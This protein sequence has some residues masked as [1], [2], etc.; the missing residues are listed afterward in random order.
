[1]KKILLISLLIGCTL[2]LKAIKHIRWGTTVDP[3]NGLT[4]TWS[5]TGAADSIQWGYTTSFEKGSSLGVKRAGY[6]GSFFNYVFP[7]LNPNSTI[8]YKLYDSSTKSWGTQM[9]YKTAPPID[10]KNFSFLGLGDSRSGVSTWNKISLLADAKDVALTVFNGDIVNSGSSA[11]DW[12]GWFDNGVQYL[13]NNLVLHALGNHETSSTP[14][15]QNIFEFPKVNGAPSLY[16]A[17]TY[18][19]TI[20]ITLNSESPSNSAQLTWLNNT[21]AAANKDP[22]IMWK[23]ISFHRPFYTIGSHAGEMNSYLGTWWKAF[24]DYGVDLILN[25][26]DHMYERTKPINR[27]VSGSAPVT[28]YGSGP[29]QGRCQ[30]VC[31]GAGAPLY[32]GTPSW[33]IQ[34]YQSVYNF[35]YFE[36]KDCKMIV[37]AYTNTG[38]VIETFTLDKCSTVGINDDQNQKFNPISVM[39]NPT[40]GNFTLRYSSSLE[41]TA[42]I[43]I[44]DMQ[45]KEVASEKV[46]KSQVDMEFI[47]DMSKYAK[48]VYSVQVIMGNQKDD[49]L[50]ILK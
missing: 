43:K 46:N 42:I 15:Y 9:T 26:H 30:I 50:L 1:M 24:D 8:Y 7:A 45:G 49:A 38:S 18:G 22:K 29:G 39:P 13:Q 12:N 35:C 32:T 27:S 10:T 3:L 5:N 23:V 16:Y 20:F 37:T 48:G 11:A 2:Q 44:Y 19:N 34:K 28:T 41:G 17:C 4:I 47:Y 25:G 21:L 6:S 14:T 40:E 33:F 31:G 36:V